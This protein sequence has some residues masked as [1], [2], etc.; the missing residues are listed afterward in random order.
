[1]EFKRINQRKKPNKK[2]AILLVLLLVLIIYLW[3]NMEGFL[4]LFY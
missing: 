2:R 3:Y 1:M 4:K